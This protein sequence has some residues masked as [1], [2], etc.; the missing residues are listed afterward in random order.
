MGPANVR[1]FAAKVRAIAVA[2][3][4]PPARKVRAESRTMKA[5]EATAVATPGT[6]GVEVAQSVLTETQTANLPLVPYLDTLRR[7]FTA[8]ALGGIAVR[9]WARLDDIYRYTRDRWGKAQADRYIIGMFEAFE[10]IGSRDRSAKR[11]EAAIGAEFIRSSRADSSAP[12]L[13][14][15]LSKERH[16]PSFM[17]CAGLAGLAPRLAPAVNRPTVPVRHPI[18]LA[19]HGRWLPSGYA[20][21]SHGYHREAR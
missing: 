19:V 21:I 6:V 11:I 15:M 20:E 5:G 17:P 7:V 4:A 12:S 9:I 8:V 1:R 16:Q 2:K 13:P 14:Q 3:E 10:T 18:P